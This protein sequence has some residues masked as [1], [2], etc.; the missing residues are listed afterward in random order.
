MYMTVPE[1]CAIVLYIHFLPFIPRRLKSG[2]KVSVYDFPYSDPRPLLSPTE[3]KDETRSCLCVSD[4]TKQTSRPIYEPFH[5][6]QNVN[7]L[8]HDACIYDARAS[9]FLSFVEVT[10][11]AGLH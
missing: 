4:I 10:L 6:R 1:R 8:L 2:N 11:R 7:I 9:I 3:L 5:L